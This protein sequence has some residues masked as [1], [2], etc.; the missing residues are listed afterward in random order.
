MKQ[1]LF[2]PIRIT[3]FNWIITILAGSF[4]YSL[5]DAYFTKSGDSFLQIVRF[6]GAATVF[7]GI[8]SLPALVVLILVNWRLNKR[9]VSP[10]KYQVLHT[11]VQLILVAGSFLWL[12]RSEEH[13]SELQ[14]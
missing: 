4:I 7:S 10:R 12:I 3:L 8:Y 1:Q 14:S 2:I 9:P 6:A 13:T 5:L 11:I